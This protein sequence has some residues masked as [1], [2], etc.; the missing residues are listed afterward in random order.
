[1]FDLIVISVLVVSAL[2]GMVRGAVK[3]LIT[4]AAFV[5]AAVLTIF[6][7]ALTSPI[8][9]RLIDPDWLGTVTVIV[10]VFLASYVV[11]RLLGGVLT[12]RVRSVDTVGFLDR[13]VGVGFGLIRAM[14]VLGVFNLAFHI[15]TPP[16]R[17]PVW[18]IGSRSY[19]L[20]EMAGQT[21]QVVF[22]KGAMVFGEVSPTF[23]N[24]LASPDPDA[25]SKTDDKSQD[26]ASERGYDPGARKK[27][28]D[29][30]EKA[31]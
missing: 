12:S 14:V 6:T 7:L 2:I 21:L 28:D 23:Q 9:R 15:A 24:P 27:M 29:L 4:V 22:Q 1:M 13:V 20:T 16:E 25:K 19:P 31:R 18:V 11:L 30:V 3:E 17:A 8:G 10:L 5:L 26:K